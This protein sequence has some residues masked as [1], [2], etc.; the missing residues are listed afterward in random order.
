MSFICTIRETGKGLPISSDL[1]VE[2]LMT[3]HIRYKISNA[4]LRGLK[5]AALEHL[6]YLHSQHQDWLVEEALSAIKAPNTDLFKCLAA[7]AGFREPMHSNSGEFAA[8]MDLVRQ[9]VWSSQVIAEEVRVPEDRVRQ[10]LTQC[11][12]RYGTAPFGITPYGSSRNSSDG[13]SWVPR[14]ISVNGQLSYRGHLYCLGKRYRGRHA[15]V[16]EVATRLIV[17]CRDRPRLELAVRHN[18]MK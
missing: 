11:P 13:K 5:Q 16:K 4:D 17:D 7:A 3:I 1:T 8:V 18:L 2:N 15:L 10:I 14:K 9:G 12:I 6:R